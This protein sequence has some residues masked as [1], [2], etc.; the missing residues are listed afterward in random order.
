MWHALAYIRSGRHVLL[1]GLVCNPFWTPLFW[2]LSYHKK[3][4][5]SPTFSKFS[6]FRIGNIK[7][8]TAEYNWTAPTQNTAHNPLVQLL[9]NNFGFCC[10]LPKPVLCNWKQVFERS[11]ADGSCKY[12]I[13]FIIHSLIPPH[14]YL[15]PPLK[16]FETKYLLLTLFCQILWPIFWSMYFLLKLWN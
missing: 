7:W 16:F 8:S 6:R 12:L 13:I 10:A 9:P 4:D 5:L 1:K 14:P 15:I 11:N 2:A 3:Y